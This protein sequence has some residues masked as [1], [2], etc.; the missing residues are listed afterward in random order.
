[1]K[2]TVYNM[3]HPVCEIAH[4]KSINQSTEMSFYRTT[5]R[6]E[7]RIEYSRV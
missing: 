5:L 1:M 7:L 3:M 2:G 4:Y 6:Q